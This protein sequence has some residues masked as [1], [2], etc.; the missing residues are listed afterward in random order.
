MGAPDGVKT[1]MA[2]LRTQQAMDRV[3]RKSMDDVG[4]GYSDFTL[5]EALLHLGPL[6]PTQLGAKISLTKGSV[7]AAIDRL[8]A[9]GYVERASHES[10]GRSCR[11]R[12]TKAG[13][14]VID[15][16]WKTHKADIERV[17]GRALKPEQ[18][19]QLFSLLVALR[20]VAEQ[21][22][23]RASSQREDSDA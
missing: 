5:L 4:L 3:A 23:G 15:T 16:A 11:V 22:Q 19:K 13:K 18:R 17:V 6:M 12:L 1:W 10:D 21:E 20:H 7:T 14:T 9:K 8:S 2:L